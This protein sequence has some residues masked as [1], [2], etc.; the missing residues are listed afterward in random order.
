MTHRRRSLLVMSALL[1]ATACGS[2]DPTGPTLLTGGRWRLDSLRTPEGIT[3]TVNPDRYT[4]EFL[5]AT[6]VSAQADCNVCN[7]N[8][9]TRGS[10]AITIGPLA[11]TRVACAPGSRGN[12]YVAL[13]TTSKLF[14]QEGETLILV[15]NTGTLLYRP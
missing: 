4:L 7:G 14:A 1:L 2:D 9:D 5:D 15:S 8:Y 10:I 13:L 3:T 12:D 6:R 11:C